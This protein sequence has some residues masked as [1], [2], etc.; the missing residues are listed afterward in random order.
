MLLWREGADEHHGQQPPGTPLFWWGEDQRRV[1][2]V[3]H[4]RRALPLAEAAELALGARS[5]QLRLDGQP[6]PWRG[7]LCGRIDVE[8]SGL[9]VEA[10]PE[11]E[12]WDL[13]V[14][15]LVKA[16]PRLWR[17]PWRDL[18]AEATATDRRRSLPGRHELLPSGAG[19]QSAQG[20]EAWTVTVPL[21]EGVVAPDDL[22]LAVRRDAFNLH[23]AGQEEAPL[24]A[25]EACGRLLPEK[26][27]WR[28]SQA[29]V[30][31]TLHKAEAKPWPDLLKT[32]FT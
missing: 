32:W 14:L 11:A 22:R 13:L 28:V 29:E 31:L 23:V 9:S 15:T 1:R 25:G 3:A 21:R 24:F 10:G 26:C 12:L 18:L 8:A 2:V 7:A 5:A 6:T 16:E 17:A 27:H 4:T 19:W 20:R 30:T